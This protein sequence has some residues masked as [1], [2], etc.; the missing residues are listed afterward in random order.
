[1]PYFNPELVQF[2]TEK[3]LALASALFPFEEWIPHGKESLSP[4]VAW[5]EATRNSPNYTDKGCCI[6]YFEA[7]EELYFWTYD[8]L[9]AIVGK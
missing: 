9:R 2:N 8:E 1:M 3:S 4:K 6:C 7:A 5:L